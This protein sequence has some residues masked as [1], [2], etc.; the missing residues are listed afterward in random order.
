MT[1]L[2]RSLLRHNR[3]QRGLTLV[4]LMIG[5]ALGL[6]VLVGIGYIYMGS[7]QS[8]KVQDNMARIQE[9]GRYAM[10]ILAREIR[11][12][13]YQGCSSATFKSTIND[14]AT[15]S[16]NYLWDFNRDAIEGFNATGAGTWS[17]ATSGSPAT[18]VGVSNIDASVV[19]GTDVI[20][21]RLTDNL[22]IQ[23]IG[24]P[25]DNN[26]S[27]TTADLKVTSNTLLAN[28]MVVMA[29]NCTNAAVFQITNFN[30]NQNV[31][32]N[33]GTSSPGNSTKD[34]GACFVDGEIVAVSAKS[35]FIKNNPA[36]IPALYRKVGSASAEELVEGIQDMQLKFGIDTNADGAIDKYVDAGSADLD[37]S[38]EWK[39]VL[40][41]RVSLL[42]VSR[43]DNVVNAPQKYVYNGSA[44]TPTD[45]KLRFVFTGTIGVRN[46]LL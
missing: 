22:G 11:M 26:C 9:N 23:I 25:T 6:V 31:V 18:T 44:V 45:R 34:L 27:A 41:V 1:T 39:T 43:E 12:A 35:Y 16:G 37:T 7:R 8:Y 5:M 36:S 28:D 2:A 33:T 10:E 19:S 15:A 24:Q 4:E 29:T 38:A 13:G 42:L 14:Q 21:M 46:R 30:S 40:S 20:A 32:H 3:A 17:S